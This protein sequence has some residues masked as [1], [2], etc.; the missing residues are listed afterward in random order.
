[1]NWESKRDRW[2]AYNRSMYKEAIDE[3]EEFEKIQKRKKLEDVEEDYD[4]DFKASVDPEQ[5]A[6]LP[7]KHNK[8]HKFKGLG[9]VQNR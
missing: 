6:Q 9:G 1:M 7:N 3:Q 2:N 5:L 8:N 4:K